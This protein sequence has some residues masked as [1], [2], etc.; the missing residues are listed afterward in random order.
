M[1]DRSA[2]LDFIM[3]L[4]DQ[5][6]APLAK[7]KMGLDSI[8]KAGERYTKRAGIALAGMV[9]AGAAIS[10]S[11]QPALEQHRAL[12]ELKS[13]GVAQDALDALNRKSLAFSIAYGDNAQ[14]FV[15]SAYTIEGAIKGLTGRQLATFTNTSNVLAKATRTDA[16]TMGTYVGTMYNL[17]KGQAD[18][19]GKG[20]WVERLGGQ[21]ALAVQLFRTSG[22]QIG[23]AFKAA[24]GLASTAGVDLAEQMAV[25]G[26]LSSTMDGGAAGG[27]YKAF[28][29]NVTGASEKL[30]MSFTDQQ[31]RLLPMLDILEK[32]RGRFGDLSIETNGKAL[33]DAF[34]G[35]AARLISTLMGDTERLANGMNQLGRV[36]GLEQAERMAKAMVDPWQQFGAAVQALRIA[37]GQALIPMLSPLMA[38]L[39]GIAQTLLRW[40]E[41]FPNLTRVIG[42]GVLIVL[43]LTA[44]LAALTFT[45]SLAKMAWLGLST[46]WSVATAAAWLFNAAL[47]ANPITWVVMAIIALCVAIAAA[48]IYWDE[49]V[50]AIMD[51][52]AFK[53]ISEQLGAL[54]AWFESMGGWRGMAKAAWDGIVA[55]F[56]SAINNLIEILNYIPGVEIEARMGAIPELPGADMA[57]E[58]NAHVERARKAQ[59]A[60]TG[61]IP[62]LSPRRPAAV[63]PG[64]LLSSI[65]NTT[66]NKGTHVEKVEIHTGK[67]M[68]PMELEN[69]LEMAAG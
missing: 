4:N 5:I 36:R 60:I 3:R 41:L 38:R 29:E 63:P 27:A 53:W 26:T 58:A 10:R 12:G 45:I 37:F 30:G 13:L 68:N 55:I 33:R 20:A 64:G 8:S 7:V 48:V 23:E 43:G 14:A 1:A 67:A 35:E 61:A 51:T 62:E 50:A 24:G 21:T 31:G 44:G 57:I 25:L 47:W 9:G 56:H 16:A 46:V 19:I 32:L 2:K 66:Q 52:A 65:Q 69:L 40:I 11:M 34:G 6:T 54:S 49:I 28:F 18:A 22:A 42:T 39:T 17:F 59:E 15:A